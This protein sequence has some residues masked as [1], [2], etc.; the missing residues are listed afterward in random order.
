MYCLDSSVDLIKGFY[1]S[2][3]S[4]FHSFLI[5]HNKFLDSMS[6]LKSK[7]TKAVHFVSASRILNEFSQI[8][9]SSNDDGEPKGSSAMPSLNVLRG[10]NLVNVSIIIVRYFGGTLL[11]VG[12]L[13][14]AY[15][16][17]TKDCI[18]TAKDKSLIIPFQA[19]QTLTLL[20]PYKIVNL[21]EHRANAM[22]LSVQKISFESSGICMQFSGTQNDLAAFKIM[23]N[24][25]FNF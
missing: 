5:P 3:G 21:I 8:V 23:Y 13:V 19:L 12:G 1:E 10:E 2:K 24:A 14:R 15:T 25:H 17:A 4:T 7:H 18:K 22:S 16:N 9:E 11:G 6:L 20:I